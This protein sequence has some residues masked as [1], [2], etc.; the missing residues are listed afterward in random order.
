MSQVRIPASEHNHHPVRAR[1]RA[2]EH[3]VI[4]ETHGKPT[5]VIVSY[6]R[7]QRLTRSARTPLEVI[8][9]PDAAAVDFTLPYFAEPATSADL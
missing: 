9:D 5:V 6:E 3:D 1:E 4:V 8:A 2:R 7:Y